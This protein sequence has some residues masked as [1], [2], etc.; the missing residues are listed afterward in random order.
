VS[1]PNDMPGVFRRRPVFQ[2]VEDQTHPQIREASE[3][4]WACDELA[5]LT[6]EILATLTLEPNQGLPI[7]RL[8]PH[9]EGWR[10]KFEDLRVRQQPQPRSK[11]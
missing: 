1:S 9:V 10:K 3:A 6:R 4:L 2:A 11:R 5:L 8:K 7:G